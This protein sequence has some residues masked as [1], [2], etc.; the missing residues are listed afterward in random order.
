VLELDEPAR[1]IRTHE[2]GGSIRRWDH[3]LQV[4]PIGDACCRYR[5]T[6]V[7]DA[8]GLTPFAAWIASGIFRYRHRRW[9]HLVDKHLLPKG[10]RYSR[11]GA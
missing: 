7:L 5:D 6:L 9:R 2:H 10:P 1:T 8:G 3:T 11:A 4:E